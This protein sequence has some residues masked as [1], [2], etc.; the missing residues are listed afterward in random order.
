[1]FHQLGVTTCS[2]SAILPCNRRRVPRSNVPCAASLTNACLN[3]N[4]AS[5][6]RATLK[7]QERR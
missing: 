1:M 6:I 3:E 7:K 4:V 2:A 5:G